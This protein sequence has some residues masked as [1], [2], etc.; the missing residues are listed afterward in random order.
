M[1][2]RVHDSRHMRGQAMIEYVLITTA[3][4]IVMFFPF[5]G[6]VSPSEHLAFAFRNFFRG[7]SF[8]V[9]VL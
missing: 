4:A 5:E 7:F 1:K 2:M 6:G 3:V 9:S 8:L